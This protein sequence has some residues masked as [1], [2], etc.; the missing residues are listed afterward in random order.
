MYRV[1]SVLACIVVFVTT[2]AMILPAITL[3][4]EM[5]AEQ[6]GI[7]AE[8]SNDPASAGA[9]IDDS[10][11]EEPE[12]EEPPEETVDTADPEPADGEGAG[13]TG[14]EDADQT[15]E[16]SK[17]GADDTEPADGNEG[18][19]G[20]DAAP[21]ADSSAQEAEDT[22]TSAGDDAQAGG[23]VEAAGTSATEN[24]EEGRTEAIVEAAPEIELIT[25]DTQLVFEGGDYY[26]YAD[27]GMS[28]KLPVGV[29]LEAREITRETDPEVYE[30]YYAKTLSEMQDKYN[31]NT[32]LSFARFYDIAF[33]YEGKEIEPAGEV[34]VR[35]EY[36]EALEVPEETNVDAIHFDAQKDEK[37]TVI[38]SEMKTEDGVSMSGVEFT[39]GSFSVYGVVG[40]VIE[41]TILASD[42]RNYTVTVEFGSD[43]GIPV[44]TDLTVEEITQF[45]GASDVATVYEHYADK[46]GEALDL[47]TAIFEYAR[48][49]DISLVKDGEKIQPAEGSS[50]NVKI[51]LADTSSDSL[52]VLHFEGEA[53]HSDTDGIEEQ[54]VFDSISAPVEMENS[55]VSGTVTF[56]TSAFSVYA[57]VEEQE[58]MPSKGWNKVATVDDIAQLSS[59]GVGFLIHHPDG[60]YFTNEGYVVKGT[61]T[62]ILK[63]AETSDPDT[64]IEEERFFTILSSKQARRTSSRYIVTEMTKRNC[65]S[66]REATACP[67]FRGRRRLS[68]R[69]AI[70]PEMPRLSTC[71]DQVDITG[72]C[73]AA[74]M[75]KALQLTPARRI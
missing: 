26:V 15:D 61:R 53:V 24:S 48:F 2:Y 31:E 68:L 51:E 52:K 3:D 45:E 9:V 23:T 42:G 16:N 44:G 56:E 69:S 19:G 50:V 66:D 20:E 73:R 54:T 1:V 62:G 30:E 46:V 12:P 59:E 11:T 27:F 4:R 43:A 10:D 7:E 28:A 13:Q 29:K 25:E 22:G 34:K 36:K 17:Q 63:T 5:A 75:E 35:I 38:E 60:Y 71:S 39:S 74:Q 8:V 70:S 67:L 64:A 32:T 55:S 41:K 47:D 49:F 21:A 72:I 14:E 18:Q 33:M 65:I 6:P 58:P 57:I 37:P 40:S